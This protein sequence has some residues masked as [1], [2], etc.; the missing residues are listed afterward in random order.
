MLEE[1]FKKYKEIKVREEVFPE[2]LLTLLG[3]TFSNFKRH[4][5]L[6]YSTDIK[7][8]ED[9]DIKIEIDHFFPVSFEKFAEIVLDYDS[10]ENFW[11]MF[12]ARQ[13]QVE[14]FRSILKA[15]EKIKRI[16]EE[17]GGRTPERIEQI[18]KRKEEVNAIYH[19]KNDDG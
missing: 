7:E 9:R 11:K 14:F 5:P 1:K 18:R 13:E 15:V 16:E 12:Q 2:N 3:T 6:L 19:R 10:E 8:A 17:K 4:Y